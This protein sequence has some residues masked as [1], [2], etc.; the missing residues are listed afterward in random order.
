M[1]LKNASGQGVYA[2]AYTVS[3][4]LPRTGDAANITGSYTLDG[5]D[6]AGFGTAHP[7]EVGGGVYWQPLAQAETNANA[8][9]YRWASSTS[10]VQIDP[11][12]VL[13]AGDPSV[14][15][16]GVNIVDIAGQAASTF[17]GQAQAGT[18][19]TITL[20][21]GETANAQGCEIALVGGTGDGQK[22]A[23]T[24]YNP[25]TRVATVYCPQGTGGNWATNPDATTL[26][27]INDIVPVVD[28]S[29]NA[30]VQGAFKL[31]TA[32][33]FEF[34]MV[35]SSDHAAGYTGGSVTATREI[36]GAG[37][38]TAA[39]TVAQVGTTNRYYF[40]G[41]AADFDGAN[42]T[43]TFTATGADPVTVSIN[44]TP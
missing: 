31:N 20:A 21:A 5:T 15:A 40:G 41:T 28:A 35:Q 24:S 22:A 13:T 32:A 11:V 44:T 2:Y 3:T 7:T 18:A 29:G 30:R 8:A 26:Y 19:N 27:A 38:T 33:G 1:L 42:V 34:A 4:G 6:H 25:A 43:F 37:T 14:A 16:I 36:D 9:A 10:G 23:C 17:T 39:G 12:M